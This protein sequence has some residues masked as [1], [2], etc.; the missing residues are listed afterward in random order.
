MN[1]VHEV[2][3]FLILFTSL[4]L[5]YYIYKILYLYLIRKFA[6]KN[7]FIVADV[8]ALATSVASSFSRGVSALILD[9][10]LNI[11]FCLCFILYEARKEKHSPW[12]YFN[13][14][15]IKKLPTDDIKGF[16]HFFSGIDYLFLFFAFLGLLGT[17]F[18]KNPAMLIL[19]LAL[20]LGDAKLRQSKYYTELLRPILA[21]D[22]IKKDGL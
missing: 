17:I 8:L 12:F 22:T 13:R 20:A 21:P 14:H 3:E 16:W 6:R 9:T 19:F 18:W 4:L 11:I 10:P 7:L 1:Y 2:T 15:D 5:W